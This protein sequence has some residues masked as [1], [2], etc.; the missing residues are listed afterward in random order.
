MED[1]HVLKDIEI[2]QQLEP[3]DQDNIDSIIDF[4]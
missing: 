3:E 1:L 4:T 2:I